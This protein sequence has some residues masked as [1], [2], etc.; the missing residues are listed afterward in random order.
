[1]C[2]GKSCQGAAFHTLWGGG[3]G[4]A[5][6]PQAMLDPGLVQNGT[7]YEK[8]EIIIVCFLHQFSAFVIVLLGVSF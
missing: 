1:M 8:N 4:A 7:F 5:A 3:G 2:G 6:P